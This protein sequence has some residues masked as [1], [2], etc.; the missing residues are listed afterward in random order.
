MMQAHSFRLGFRRSPNVSLGIDDSR[1]ECRIG[2]GNPALVLCSK[3][4]GTSIKDS[5][6]L[7]FKSDGW[8]SEAEAAQAAAKY[9]PVLQ[10]ALAKLCVGADFGDRG[11]KSVWTQHGLAMLKQQTGERALNDE[12]GV[13]VYESEPPP[14]FIS[15]SA[16]A[17][18]IV[19]PGR[20]ELAFSQGA[21]KGCSFSD[22]EALAF[23]L[24][25]ASFFQKSADT[26]LLMLVMAIEALLDPPPRPPD[27]LAHVDSMIGATKECA[28][29]SPE[30]RESLLGSMKWLRLESIRRAG[31]RLA[32]E[33]LGDREYH[34]KKAPGFFAYCY[35]LR[36]RLVHGKHPFPTFQEVNVAAGS[37]ETFV[38]D[39]LTRPLL[40]VEL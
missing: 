31:R 19:D 39:L 29:L 35:D 32:A 26:R 7:V 21:K 23:K 37:L 14:I 27:A 13:M 28:T 38:S 8:P 1:W 4:K 24:F 16:S 9:I 11:P 36:S 12:Q 25:N 20:F 2:E 6:R 34:N 10:V 18:R 40:N 30:E 22:S 3:A 15:T 5:E 33:R 17:L